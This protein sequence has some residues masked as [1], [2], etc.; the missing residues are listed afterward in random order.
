MAV[1]RAPATRCPISSPLSPSLTS[2]F[3]TLF[4]PSAVL[5]PQPLPV[6]LFLP[7]LHHTLVRTLSTKPRSPRQAPFSFPSCHQDRIFL[8]QSWLPSR[9]FPHFSAI[10]S[11]TSACRS[12]AFAPS[13]VP[14]LQVSLLAPESPLDRSFAF[15]FVGL[16]GKR[17]GKRD[18]VTISNSMPQNLRSP[19][20]SPIL[21][22]I[23][24]TV[25]PV[26]YPSPLSIV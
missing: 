25:P 8:F 11:A 2:L 19:S 15:T 1:R 24:R 17:D 23:S 3:S 26:D 18:R 20:A 14:R 12:Y 16:L 6:F 13:N 10:M 5:S 9:I 4:L 7:L 22:A 21:T